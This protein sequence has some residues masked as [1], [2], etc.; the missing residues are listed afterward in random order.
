MSFAW[1]DLHSIAE[2]LYIT[3]KETSNEA[4]LRSAINRAYYAAFGTAVAYL[5]IPKHF[6]PQG[7]IHKFICDEFENFGEDDERF[8]V[9]DYLRRMLVKRKWADYELPYADSNL[10]M[11]A[12]DVVSD[13]DVV[14]DII[15]R[16][17]ES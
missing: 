7:S 5:K 2:N 9:A 3:G 12:E 15:E 1:K 8:R 6:L 10:K 14:I 4:M 11:D 17:A 13:A 16:A